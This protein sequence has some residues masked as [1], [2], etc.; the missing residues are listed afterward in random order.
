[1]SAYLGKST[2]TETVSRL[3]TE[4]S[5]NSCRL[6]HG[7]GHCYPGLEFVTIDWFDPVLLITLYKP[8]PDGWMDAFTAHLMTLL[9]PQFA[10][11]ALLQQRYLR[12]SP[13]NLLLGEL[14]DEI[15]AREG[16]WRF[17]LNLGTNQNTGFFLDMAPGREW[18]RHHASD[19]RVL[20]LFAYTCGFSVSAFSGGA[21][22]V[23]NVDMSRSALETGRINHQL[24]GLQDRLQRDAGFHAHDLFRSWGRLK[25][26]GAFDLIIVDPPSFQRGSFVAQQDYRK[27]IKRLP[28]LLA[29][30]ADV[31]LCLNDPQLDEQ[32]L[33]RLVVD[34][35][36]SLRFVERLNNREDFPERDSNRSLKMMH[37]TY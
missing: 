7:R 22:S 14:P 18:V 37:F 4:G 11:C 21:K 5:F 15:V 34:N 1:M 30:N 8:P 25:K 36:P 17:L 29:A 6:L 31:L 28:E 2:I 24:N 32:F 23:L 20:N 26:R 13:S 27:V 33:L 9:Q 3:V 35:A 12:G 16:E 10:G 19:R